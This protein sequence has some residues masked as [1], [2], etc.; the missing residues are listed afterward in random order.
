MTT[1]AFIGL[2]IMGSPM[3]V[4][5]AKAGHR[6]RRLQP[7]AGQ[8]RAARR[9]RV[10]ARPT[11]IADAVSDADVVG[12]MV[13]DSPDVSRRARP[14][15]A[16]SSTTR[17]PGTLVIDFSSIRPDVTAQLAE[18]AAAKGFRLLDAPGLRRRGRCEERRAVDHGRRRRR[19]TSR[20]PSRSSTRSARRSCTSA[21]AAP[22]R[23]SRRPTS[24]SSPP[25]SRRSPRLSSSSR[26]TAST[27]RR[28]SRCSAAGWP[29][30]RCWTRRSRT[31]SAARFD[32]G[33]RIDLHHKDMGIVTSAAREAGVVMPVGALV[34]QL[35]A[36]RARQ[37]RRRPRPLR[38]CCVG[39]ERP[40]TRTPPTQK[41]H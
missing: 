5:L 10:A 20:P 15:R 17:K 31:C 36:S 16:G 12:V 23:P 6:R 1:I 3:A 24:S 32:P 8:G 30:R 33:F 14:A 13:P 41:E 19:T 21:P 37:R 29:A 2:G 40:P 22:G 4:H 35:M 9:R 26:R 18:Q 25:T 28:P 11:S 7:H 34:G 39:V 27:P 38:H